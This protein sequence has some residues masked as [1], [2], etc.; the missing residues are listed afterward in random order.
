MERRKRP[1]LGTLRHHPG[2]GSYGGAACSVLRANRGL[3]A[4]LLT[5][6][7]LHRDARHYLPSMRATVALRSGESLDLCERYGLTAEYYWAGDVRPA[8]PEMEGMAAGRSAS[9]FTPAFSAVDVSCA[10]PGHPTERPLAPARRALL[11]A[12]RVP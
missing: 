8:V 9:T 2:H 4:M 12:I 10:T 7:P 5:R 6:R 3:P 11:A 1:V